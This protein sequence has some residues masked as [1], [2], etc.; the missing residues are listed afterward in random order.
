[1]RRAPHAS[2][3]RACPDGLIAAPNARL[4]GPGRME[5]LLPVQDVLEWMDP[6][7]AQGAPGDSPESRPHPCVP[8]C[9]LNTRTLA[10]VPSCR[11]AE[12]PQCWHVQPCRCAAVQDS[13]RDLPPARHGARPAWSP[14]PAGAHVSANCQVPP[15]PVF[16]SQGPGMPMPSVG[17]SLCLLMQLIFISDGKLNFFMSR[18]S[19]CTD[20]PK[21][22]L[23]WEDGL[24][25]RQLAAYESIILH[26]APRRAAPRTPRRRERAAEIPRL[27]HAETN[28][29]FYLDDKVQ[30]NIAKDPLISPNHT[31][32][33][34]P[35]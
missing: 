12:V 27:L 17:L 28:Y 5:S 16:V 20:H 10:V 31:K 6:V 14:G 21:A 32:N 25:R 3:A 15:S 8:P 11:R 24:G 7:S 1:M 13:D 9:R 34:L 33:C 22:R 18:D 26:H 29:V 2:F 19:S 23:K 30:T 35:P 4:G